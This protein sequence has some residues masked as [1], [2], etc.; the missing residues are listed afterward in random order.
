MGRGKNNISNRTKDILF[1]SSLGNT[2]REAP[3]K[4]LK[5]YSDSK[6]DLEAA[7]ES[8][9]SVISACDKKEFEAEDKVAKALRFIFWPDALR[10]TAATL[11]TILKE[12][13]DAEKTDYDP[14]ELEAFQ[15]FYENELYEFNHY[16]NIGE[17]LRPLFWGS[18]GEI[19]D[20]SITYGSRQYNLK[21]LKEIF[22]ELEKTSLNGR[23]TRDKIKS[24]ENDL[25][26]SAKD[27][28]TLHQEGY[29]IYSPDNR[30]IFSEL[31]THDMVHLADETKQIIKYG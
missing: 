1:N 27:F 13:G 3:S 16:L 10:N 8:L 20:E 9:N 2:E 15:Y 4:I 30:K 18:D 11:E 28:E 17:N 21:A 31:G 29:I 24:F 26:F 6:K 19:S 7:I 5:R 12:C 23:K 25:P 22:S 14:S